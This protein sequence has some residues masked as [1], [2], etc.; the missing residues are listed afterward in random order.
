MRRP[1][2]TVAERLGW[3][4]TFSVEYRSHP[5]ASSVALVSRID[6]GPAS[7][8]FSVGVGSVTSNFG[9]IVSGV[10]PCS[11]FVYCVTVTV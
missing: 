6:L 2:A 3:M 8:I 9:D 11:S 4:V 5:A 7:T 10:P 1:V